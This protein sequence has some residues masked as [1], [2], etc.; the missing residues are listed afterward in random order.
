MVLFNRA[1]IDRHAGIIDGFVDHSERISLRRPSEI[2]D[3]GGRVSLSGRVDLVNRDDFAGFRFGEEV[4]VMVTP[5]RSGVAAERFA[6]IGGIG[7][8]P[9]LPVHDPYFEDVSQLG[10]ANENRTGADVHAKALARAAPEQLAVNGA[11]T[12]RSTPFLSLVHRKTLSAPGSPLIM[13][14]PSSLA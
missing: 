7:A 13:R 14:S 1:V 12:R 4:L 11:G 3:R 6:G 5:P 8:W 2:V 9:R 10:A